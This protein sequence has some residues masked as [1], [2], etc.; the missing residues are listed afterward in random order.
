M[1]SKKVIFLRGDFFK[2]VSSNRPTEYAAHRSKVRLCTK[3]GG[4][5]KRTPKTPQRSNATTVWWTQSGGIAVP[6]RG[7]SN[8]LVLGRSKE[9]EVWWQ[10]I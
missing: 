9:S 4:W 5:V 8:R 10:L 7:A 2:E 6:G 1:I 3:M